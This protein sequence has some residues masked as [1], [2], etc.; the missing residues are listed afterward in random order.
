[1]DTLPLVKSL[2]E[3]TV[4]HTRELRKRWIAALRSGEYQQ[5]R[6]NLFDGVGYCGLGVLSH[7]ACRMVKSPSRL[8]D[9]IWGSLESEGEFLE[10]EVV[11][12]AGLYNDC[13]KPRDGKRPH[14][15][16][17]NDEMGRT[18]SEIADALE[19]DRNGYFK[20]LEEA[21]A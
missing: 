4:E 17:L 14:L 9:S 3:W 19:D 11:G 18:F 21:H 6:G 15:S 1:M 8:F 13:G 20:P 16:L 2:D 5:C 10:P 12:M 7:Q